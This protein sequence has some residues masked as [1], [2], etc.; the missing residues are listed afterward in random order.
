MGSC[1]AVGVAQVLE[2][3]RNFLRFKAS[4]AGRKATR[5]Q[6]DQVITIG[7]EPLEQALV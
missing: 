5:N 2:S 3:G 6:K 7:N 1:R 4:K